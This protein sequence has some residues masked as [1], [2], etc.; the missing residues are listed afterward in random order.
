MARRKKEVAA[1][2]TEEQLKGQYAYTDIDGSIAEEKPLKRRTR[3][4]Y[5]A[6]EEASFLAAGKTS[7]R[8]GVKQKRINMAFR[9][10]NYEYI[11]TMA[12]ARGQNMTDCVNDIIKASI[13]RNQEVYRKAIEFRTTIL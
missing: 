4:T 8:K 6:E 12:R 1:G 13:D 5:T 3:K 2:A 11:Q 10:E 9:P 7:G